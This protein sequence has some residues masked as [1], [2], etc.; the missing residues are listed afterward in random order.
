MKGEKRKLCAG[1]R[2]CERCAGCGDRERTDGCGGK[3]LLAF[4][5]WFCPFEKTGPFSKDSELCL[6]VVFVNHPP[7]V[8]RQRHCKQFNT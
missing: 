6:S 1:V 8:C 7:P 5:C 4:V 2:E 3:L